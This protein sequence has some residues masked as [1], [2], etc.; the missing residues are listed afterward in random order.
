MHSSRNNSSFSCAFS[1]FG[2]AQTAENTNIVI[3]TFTGITNTI[4]A[5]TDDAGNTYT[6]A[7]GPTRSIQEIVVA[8][9][10]HSAAAAI[11]SPWVIQTAY[12][13]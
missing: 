13:D 9:G 5:V 11:A 12:F 2:F 10:S 7:V 4:S 6:L 8:A 3:I 1:V